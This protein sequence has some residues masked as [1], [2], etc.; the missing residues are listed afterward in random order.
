LQVVVVRVQTDRVDLV[1][2]EAVLV[3]ME[4]EMEIPHPVER[5]QL[6]TLAQEAAVAAAMRRRCT[7]VQVVQ[8]LLLSPISILERRVF[9]GLNIEM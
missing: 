3:E 9:L 7:V 8:V 2:Q 6:R 5:M 1:K 4:M